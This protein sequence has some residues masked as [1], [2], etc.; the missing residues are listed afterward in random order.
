M[1]NPEES[2]RAFSEDGVASRL[3]R[4]IDDA[5]ERRTRL[6]ASARRRRELDEERRT[7][8][9]ASFRRWSE[10]VALPTMTAA[11]ARLRADGGDGRIE[12]RSSDRAHHQR[13][14][15]WMTLDGP[16]EAPVRQDRNPFVQF[17]TSERD[18]L[19]H[20]WEGDR[21]LDEGVGRETGAYPLEQ[22]TAERVASEIV[23]VLER[24]SAHGIRP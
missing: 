3:W 24:A 13:L 9:E 6:L 12:E 15:L 17:E 14:T 19:V 8:F 7:D 21:V 5:F 23:E 18:L 2:D 16:I 4:G 22:L 1:T 10:E 20:V 11:I